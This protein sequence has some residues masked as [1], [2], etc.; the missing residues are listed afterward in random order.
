MVPAS[1]A[2][3]RVITVDFGGGV[4]DFLDLSTTSTTIQNETGA[5][6]FTL[7]RNQ[8]S[9]FVLWLASYQH[10]IR[11]TNLFV[12][13]AGHH[14][15]HRRPS[16]TELG[17][18]SSSLEAPAGVVNYLRCQIWC[19]S[20]FGGCFWGA[21]FF[22]LLFCFFLSSFGWLEEFWARDRSRA[23]KSCREEICIEQWG[24]WWFR[25]LVR[26][27]L[28]ELPAGSAWILFCGR[29]VVHLILLIFDCFSAK[30]LIR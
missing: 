24:W 9:S 21:Y 8:K 29:V 28:E 23:W 5:H 2:I 4:L 1:R 19:P 12:R 17:S 16:Q 7:K 6:R 30:L 18:S 14:H 27:R 25:A 22:T 11:N 15:R 3:A 10:H 20:F 26:T 13:Q